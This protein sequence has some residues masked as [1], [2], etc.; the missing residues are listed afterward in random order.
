MV[1]PRM[2]STIAAVFV[3]GIAVAAVADGAAGPV[4]GAVSVQGTPVAPSAVLR[5]ALAV[6]E[7]AAY[8]PDLSTAQRITG[9]GE[10]WTLVRGAA[11]GMCVDI[12]DGTVTCASANEIA[13][14]RFGVTTIAPPPADVEAQLAAARRAAVAAG[15]SSSVAA[16]VRG[17][18]VRRGLVPDGTT[19]VR[20]LRSSGQVIATAAVHGNAYR[21]GIGA[22]G[23]AAAL[24]LVASDGSATTVPL[25]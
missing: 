1:S 24:V 12:A 9:A 15:Q 8:G 18:A 3:G 16:T 10:A 25:R 19:E 6:E 14:G 13:A 23:D 4:P 17:A 22:E 20:A 2:L 11:G 21:L 5:G 7:T